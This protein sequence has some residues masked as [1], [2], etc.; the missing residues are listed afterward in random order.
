MKNTI[1]K[2]TYEYRATEWEIKKA[3]L[4]EL[5][6]TFEDGLCKVKVK[7][8]P[9]Q[10]IQKKK[11]ILL[12][13]LYILNIHSLSWTSV[14]QLIFQKTFWVETSSKSSIVHA[15]MSFVKTKER[16]VSLK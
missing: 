6:V 9:L 7:T 1:D 10:T 16:K 15:T 13:C 11:Q 5:V 4:G 3:V 8:G 2:F 12:K 14:M